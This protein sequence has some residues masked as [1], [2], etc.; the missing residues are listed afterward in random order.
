MADYGDVTT[1]KSILEIIGTTHDARL[2]LLNEVVS[3]ELEAVLGLRAGSAFGTAETA[4]ARTFLPPGT[5]DM[6][7]LTPPVRAITSITVDGQTLTAG[8]DYQLVQPIGSAWAAIYRLGGAS[9]GWAAINADGY[10][11]TAWT[12]TVV[13]TGQWADQGQAAVDPLIIEAANIIVAGYFRKDGAQDGEVSGP[14]GLTY[15]PGNPWNDSRV[16]RLLELYGV[17][18][19]A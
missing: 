17:R 8:T 13:V 7:V 1:I 10:L 3:R 11:S 14:D 19:A 15:R 2:A 18:R 16:K 12:G 9:V 4:Y 5:S 6:L